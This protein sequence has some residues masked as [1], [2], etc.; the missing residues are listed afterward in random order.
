MMYPVPILGGAFRPYSGVM[1]YNT[2]IYG[3]GGKTILDQV[4]PVSAELYINFNVFGVF[5]GFYALGVLAAGLQRRYV[6]AIH[7]VER[8][9]WI[10][11]SL[12]ILLAITASIAVV[13]Q[14]LLYMC[15][16][17]FAVLAILYKTKQHVI[18]YRWRS[19]RT[20]IVCL[21]HS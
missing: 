8:Y 1:I 4:I 11:L 7:P 21:K 13:S 16:P 19:V 10:Q 3:Y 2:A 14:M 9:C 6:S 20:T 15:L 12:Y 18:V 17:Y 5:V